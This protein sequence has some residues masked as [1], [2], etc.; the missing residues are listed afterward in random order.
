MLRFTLRHPWPILVGSLVLSA[1]TMLSVF[2]MG[3]EFLP[4]FNEGTLTVN[5]QLPP[6]TS[7]DES[8]RVAARAEQSLLQVPEVVSVSRRTGRAEQD[9]H[10]EG[11]NSSEIDVRLAP[12]ER[13]KP[14][15]GGGPPRRSGPARVRGRD[16]PAA[17]PSRCSPT[18]ATG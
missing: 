10:A 7:L 5:L 11:V 4:P 3:S 8:G 1:V 17:R 6:G 13:P 2:G 15:F 16:G 14:G 12:H 18:S 9:E